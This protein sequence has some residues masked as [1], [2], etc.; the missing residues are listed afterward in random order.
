MPASPTDLSFSRH[1]VLETAISTAEEAWLK[2][3]MVLIVGPTGSGKSTLALCFHN[4]TFKNRP[5]IAR[6]AAGLTEH[7]FESEFFG[8]V[9][10]A[11]TGAVAAHPGLAGAVGEGSL[12]LEG[13]EDLSL[14][15]QAKLLRFLQTRTYRPVGATEGKPFRG[16]L[17]FTARETPLNLNSQGLMRE[18][19]RYRIEGNQLQL[20]SL[21]QRPKDLEDIFRSML[22]DIHRETGLNQGPS[23]AE[24]K[25]LAG[26]TIEG[27]LHGLRN[28]ILRSVIKGTTLEQP[29]EPKVPVNDLPDSGS[30]R[31]DLRVLEKRLI[32]R[33]LHL[34]PHSRQE[35]AHHLGISKRA[36]MYKLKAYNLN[37]PGSSD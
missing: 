37:E 22:M 35:L 11:F 31:G 21:H 23:A 33:G 25:Q 17:I 1:K 16:Q 32:E 5:F 15:V 27:N 2:T 10:G 9:K 6:D 24:G 4:R 13:I 20:P 12:C 18:D 8:H 19:F 14:A 26:K 7:R 3:G 29:V 28:L 30:L 34:Y 36:L